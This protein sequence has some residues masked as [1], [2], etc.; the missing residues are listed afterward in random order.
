[1]KAVIKMTALA[2]LALLGDIGEGIEAAY[3]RGVIAIFSINTLAIPF[4]EA[5]KR[6]EKDLSITIDNLLRFAGIWKQ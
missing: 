1:M 3:D 6:S 2:G 4:S 5:R